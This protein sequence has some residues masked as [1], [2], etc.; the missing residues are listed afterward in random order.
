MPDLNGLSYDQA[1][2]KLNSL[3]LYLRASGVSYYNAST[4]ALDQ[5]VGAGELVD[6]G[7]VVSV[8]FVDTS[9][10]DAYTPLE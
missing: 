1:K 10:T 7:T 8:R 4:K 5:S 3:G 6:R 2:E 9:V